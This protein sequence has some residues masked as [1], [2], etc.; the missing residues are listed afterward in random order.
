MKGFLMSG[1]I[2]T[3]VSLLVAVFVS[4]SVS[5]IA[6]ETPREAVNEFFSGL[7]EGNPQTYEMYM[8]NSYINLIA[9][10]GM[11][12][13]DASRM[14]SVLFEDLNWEI[15]DSAE[16]ENI[17]V[18]KVTLTNNDFSRVLES[19]EKDSHDYVMDNLYEDKVTDKDQLAAACLDIYLNQLED[20]AA[21]SETGEREVFIPL[22]A[23]GFSGWRVILDDEIMKAAAGG[24]V[25]PADK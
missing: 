25:L 22:E 17:A 6:Q 24:L 3:I 23:D 14:R 11:S 5:N 7:T 2:N 8:D 10:S 18:C 16:R 21:G 9:N 12:D 20:A 15:T 19:Y 1:I 4:G 13:E